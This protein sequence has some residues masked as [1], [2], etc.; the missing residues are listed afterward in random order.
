MSSVLFSQDF[1][2]IKEKLDIPRQALG[3]LHSDLGS[4]LGPQQENLIRIR[5]MFKG[6]DYCAV[7]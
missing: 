3:H 2:G 5:K 1:T 4:N 7:L 6:P